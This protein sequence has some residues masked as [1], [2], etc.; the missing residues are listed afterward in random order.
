VESRSGDKYRVN[1]KWA[2]EDRDGNVLY[3]HGYAL[4]PDGHLW[5]CPLLKI[6]TECHKCEFFLYR[7]RYLTEPACAAVEKL[8]QCP[9]DYSQSVRDVLRGLQSTS[10]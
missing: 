4:N 3:E 5:P 6:D 8:D 9:D 2:V 10:Y 7:G 1:Y